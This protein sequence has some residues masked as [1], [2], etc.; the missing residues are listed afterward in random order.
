MRIT[1][2]VLG[3]AL[4]A[5]MALLTMAGPSIG[6]LAGSLRELFSLSTG[7]IGQLNAGYAVVAAVISPFTGRLADR[8]GGRNTMTIGFLVA[9][10][11]FFLFGAASGFATLL[12]AAVLSGVPNGMSNQGTNKYISAEVPAERRGV[13]TGVKQSGVMFGVFLA[14]ALL[15]RGVANFGYRTTMWTVTAI[16][17]AAAAMIRVVLPADSGQAPRA[18]VT[19]AALPP[20]IR[21]LALYAALMGGAIG[22][23]SA[24]LALYLE[25][26]LDFTRQTAGALIGIT[27][28]VAVFGRITLGRLT[29]AVSSFAPVLVAIA[30]GATISFAVIRLSTEVGPWLIWLVPLTAGVTTSAWNAPVMLASMRLVPTSAAGRSAGLVMFGFMSGYSITPPIFGAAID[31][32]GSYNL[33]WSMGMILCL[34]AATVGWAWGRQERQTPTASNT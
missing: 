14:G 31:R 18:D 1:P 10:T 13:I 17:L 29:Q 3:P 25:D 30:L 7:Q 26:E 8:I 12:A 23:Q 6:I 28:L 34:A 4:V 19:P 9:A 2:W 27:G 32:F 24:F 5:N 22:S 21:W 15:P 33:P 11:V 20:A 16:A